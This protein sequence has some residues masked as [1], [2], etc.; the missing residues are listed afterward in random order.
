MSSKNHSIRYV[1]N[2]RQWTFASCTIPNLRLPRTKKIK[3]SREPTISSAVKHYI[4]AAKV[5]AKSSVAVFP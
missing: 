1:G 5:E 3:T 2:V 4:F